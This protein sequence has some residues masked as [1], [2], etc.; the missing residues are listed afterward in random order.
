MDDRIDAAIVGAGP[1][2]LSLAAHLR[3]TGLRFRQFG[4]PMQLW[5]QA[6]PRGMYL[7]SQGYASSLSDPSGR[8][9]LGE[10]C[11]QTG[12]DYADYGL[13]VALEDFV[14]YGHW[15]RERATP[16]LEE[17]HVT[18]VSARDGG[19]EVELATTERVWAREVVIAAGVQHFAQVP[20]VLAG[21]PA[22]LCT[23]SSAHADLGGFGG[24]EVV[25]VGAGQSALESAALLREQGASVH[26][27]ARTIRLVWNGDPLAA[28]RSIRHRLREPEAPLGSGWAT[29]FYSCQPRLYRR[30]P[31]GRRV[32]TART[33][34]G[35]AGAHWLRPRVEGRV[36]VLLGHVV[37][38]AEAQGN[39]VRLDLRAHHGGRRTIVADHVLA[40]TG[41]R[42]DL[43]RLSFLDD[44]LL[45][46]VR[47]VDGAPD[48]GVDFQSSVPGLY[49]AGPAVAAAFGPVMRFVYGA[50]FAAATL[51]R[52]LAPAA[53]SA[54]AASAAR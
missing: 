20:D 48:V 18:G 32:R 19:Y 28:H 1:Y 8:L 11:A 21:L 49:F 25:V 4:L 9:T 36:P 44:D 2:G 38:R 41:Y 7:K 29:W 43:S 6:M 16:G 5:E 30:L 22:R 27:V 37:E 46:R 45:A 39:R 3:A 15:F 17:V 10:F 23:H 47:T 13:P 53:W 31:V 35:P 12:R 54:E 52:R 34:L 50:A 33:A 24:R 26:V 14:A 40:A 51:A 42:P